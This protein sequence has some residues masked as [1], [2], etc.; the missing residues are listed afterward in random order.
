MT[1][2]K[3]II[4]TAVATVCMAG[5][6]AG[7]SH[8]GSGVH[9]KQSQK[10]HNKSSVKQSP[11]ETTSATGSGAGG[12]TEPQESSAT[13]IP[14]GHGAW[15]TIR[16]DY[17]VEKVGA[18]SSGTGTGG[19]IGSASDKT[20]QKGT[21]GTTGDSG[22]EGSPGGTLDR[23]QTIDQSSGGKDDQGSGWM[24]YRAPEGTIGATDETGDTTDVRGGDTNIGSE[25]RSEPRSGDSTGSGSP[26]VPR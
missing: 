20:I 14:R 23:E 11:K 2:M 22:T 8:G 7:V 12:T 19:S 6:A 1:K 4:L 25:G 26:E 3:N 13:G 9:R 10:S 16:S 18:E 21:G 17:T 24:Q 5:L 15:E